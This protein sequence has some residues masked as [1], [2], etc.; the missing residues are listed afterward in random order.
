MRNR[1]TGQVC[2]KDSVSDL[3]TVENKAKAYNLLMGYEYEFWVGEFT[4]PYIDKLYLLHI[5]KNYDYIL[6]FLV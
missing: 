1:L 2:T 3:A 4:E 6:A 5:K